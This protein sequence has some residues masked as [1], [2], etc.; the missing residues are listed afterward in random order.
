MSQKDYYIAQTFT[1]ILEHQ[2]E[3]GIN[4][5]QSDFEYLIVNK[6]LPSEMNKIAWKGSPTDAFIFCKL[7][8]IELSRFNRCFNL[9]NGKPLKSNSAGK[10]PQTDFAK[11]TRNIAFEFDSVI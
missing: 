11:F 2:Q 10:N 9:S 5:S 8:N 6:K 1:Y 3:F 7:L 4:I